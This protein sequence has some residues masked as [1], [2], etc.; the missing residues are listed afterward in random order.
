MGSLDRGCGVLGISLL[1][2]GVGGCSGESE[3]ALVG[4]GK[5]HVT[6][7]EEREARIAER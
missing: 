5:G 1:G 6:W 7:R 4:R 2:D 3:A